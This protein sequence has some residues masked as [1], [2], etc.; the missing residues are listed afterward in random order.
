[1]VSTVESGVKRLNGMSRDLFDETLN[2]REFLTKR[3]LFKNNESRT[4]GPSLY[5]TQFL[6]ATNSLV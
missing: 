4:P 3:T 2:E 5:T 1:M 6:A